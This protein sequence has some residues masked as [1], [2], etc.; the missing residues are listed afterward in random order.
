MKASVFN[1]VATV[2]RHAIDWIDRC[3][4]AGIFLSKVLFRRMYSFRHFFSVID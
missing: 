3:G 4:V 1:H 2:G